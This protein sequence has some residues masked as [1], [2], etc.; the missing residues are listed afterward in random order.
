[1]SRLDTQFD[2]GAAYVG[3]LTAGD[4]GLKHSLQAMQALIRGGVNVLE[5]GIPFSDPVADG[6]SIQKASER[7]L[8]NGVNIKQIL[9]L[10]KELRSHTDIPLVLFSYYN[11]IFNYGSGFYA[12]VKDAGADACLVVDLPIEESAD[13]LSG[14]RN[15]GLD[16]VFIVSQSS[17]AKRIRT[18][19]ESGQGMLYYTCRKGITGIKTSLPDNFSEKLLTIKKNSRL[20]V[21]AGFGISNQEMAKEVLQHADGFVVGSLFVNAA[22]DNCDY[23]SLTNLA[24]SINPGKNN[25]TSS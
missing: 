22:H 24:K 23:Q 14:C 12:D 15:A 7:A 21:V 11:P 6:P 5:I 19:S 18:I 10:V 2:N 16:P 25:D 4:G 13:Y 8:T 1:M 20:P 9:G 3:F 17:D